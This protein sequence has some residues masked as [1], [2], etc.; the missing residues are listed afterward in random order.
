MYLQGATGINSQSRPLPTLT[1]YTGER[2]G[3]VLSG[4]YGKWKM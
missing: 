2:V 1:I 3:V 4:I